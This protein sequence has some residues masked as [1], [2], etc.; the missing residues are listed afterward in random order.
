V[1]DVR[2]PAGA[3]V[4]YHVHADRMVGVSIRDART[5]FQLLGKPLGPVEEAGPV[6]S[7]WD[8]WDDALPLTH[9]GAN[10]DSVPIH[11]V[12]A[13]RVGSSGV[14]CVPLPDTGTRRLVKRGPMAMIYE[15][16]L[17][18]LTDSA[19]H[20]HTCPGLTVITTPGTLVEEGMTPA[21][22]G[23]EGMGRWGW[24]SPGHR[25]TLLNASSTAITL[26]EID[27]R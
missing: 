11:Y 15:I 16:R 26:Y 8:N 5:R 13:E 27:W 4:R 21:A 20:V 7:V 19:L 25:H 17:P 12:V 18:P 23:G 24:R 3:T 14:D 2:I 10:I 6:P 9:R 1:L 22:S